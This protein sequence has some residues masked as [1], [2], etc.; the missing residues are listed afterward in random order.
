[1][2]KKSLILK[3]VKEFLASRPDAYRRDIVDFLWEDFDILVGVD[4]VSNMLKR[5]HISR[6]K[7]HLK[8]L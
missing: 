2:V 1:M 7:V 5:E 4:C 6:K 8:H 3:G